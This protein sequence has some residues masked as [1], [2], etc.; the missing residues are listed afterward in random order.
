MDSLRIHL[1]ESGG[2]W[3]TLNSGAELST[4]ELNGRP[5][6]YES[7]GGLLRIEAEAPGDAWLCLAYDLDLRRDSV[8]NAN[9]GRF[10]PEFGHVRDQYYWLPFFGFD[11]AESVADFRLTLSAP[12]DVH[13]VTGLLQ[14]DTIIAGRRAVVATSARPTAAITL[15][16]DRRWARTRRPLGGAAAELFLT[17]SVEPSRQAID[18]ALTSV[19]GVLSRRFG[20]PNSGYVALV[21]GRALGGWGWLFRSNDMVVAGPRGGSLER[22]GAVPRAL[23][24]HEVAHGWT[25]S[26]G[27]G[28]NL[29]SEGWAMFA[30]GC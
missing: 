25:T 28:R 13:V 15:M 4:V 22:S 19:R 8:P 23:F 7:L 29:L 3:L 14:R 17:D 1:G 16:Y 2:I 24:G 12:T 9:F 18:S 21:Q 10:E 20:D 11:A 5:A 26:S 6:R 30:E 27:A